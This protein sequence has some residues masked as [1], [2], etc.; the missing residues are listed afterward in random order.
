MATSFKTVLGTTIALSVLS[1][2]VVMAQSPEVKDSPRVVVGPG[3]WR[4]NEWVFVPVAAAEYGLTAALTLHGIYKTIRGNRKAVFNDGNPGK[5][6]KLTYKEARAS[7]ES[8]KAKLLELVKGGKG[9]TV[10]QV[11]DLT[12]VRVLNPLTDTTTSNRITQKGSKESVAPLTSE[13]ITD[14]L[15]SVRAERFTRVHIVEPVS[16]QQVTF[17]PFN[18]DTLTIATETLNGQRAMNVNEMDRLSDYLYSK[19][20]TT[21]ALVAYSSLYDT[22][23]AVV[24]DSN[25][26]SAQARLVDI[27]EEISA[28]NRIMNRTRLLGGVPRVILGAGGLY[29]VYQH[30]DMLV[31]KAAD[32]LQMSTEFSVE[33]T[34]SLIEK[35]AQ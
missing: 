10:T 9:Q 7:L 2:N 12:H 8:D 11:R 3:E 5:D 4:N 13:A 1:G 21:R 17:N 14:F 22:S 18:N 20:N 16:G 30:Q 31:G 27:G 25:V 23:K 15:N 32:L 6:L 33:A 35:Y 26:A 19:M 34:K 24:A 28:N 29:L